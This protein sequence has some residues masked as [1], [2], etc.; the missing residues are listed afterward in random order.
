MTTALIFVVLLRVD[1]EQSTED[2]FG[3]EGIDRTCS[4][5]QTAQGKRH[6]E[7]KERHGRIQN[8]EASITFCLIGTYF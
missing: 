7:R 3:R 1:S 8:G 4:A 5:S 6:L 2:V